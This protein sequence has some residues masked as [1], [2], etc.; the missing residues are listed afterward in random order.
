MRAGPGFGIA[1]FLIA[2]ALASPARAADGPGP[3]MK[4]M[5]DE[6]R[7]SPDKTLS[8]EQYFNGGGDRSFSYQFWVFDKNRKNP[9]LLNADEDLDQLASYPAGFRFSPNSKWLVRMQGTGAGFATLLLYKRDGERFVPATKKPLG[10]LAHRA[11]PPRARRMRARRP[12]ARGLC[13]SP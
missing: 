2:A 9:Y 1:L 13:A 5:A 10:D 12:A 3:D 4:V 7:K 11:R 6:T 8:I